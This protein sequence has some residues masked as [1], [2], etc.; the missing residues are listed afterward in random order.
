MVF[1]VQQRKEEGTWTQVKPKER[2][3]E[4]APATAQ[5]QVYF[6]ARTELFSAVLRYRR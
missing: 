3:G 2:E 1:Y 6:D 5:P 4:N